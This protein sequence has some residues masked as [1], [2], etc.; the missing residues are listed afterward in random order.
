M[1]VVLILVLVICAAGVCWGNNSIKST[2]IKV[3]I[4]G[5][6]PQLS[7]FR[8]VQL[9]DLHGKIFGRDDRRLVSA[10]AEAEPD[11]IAITGDVAGRQSEL[12]GLPGLAGELV[13]IA[14]VYYVTGNHEWAAGLTKKID[15]IFSEYGVTVLHSDYAVMEKGGGRLVIAGIDDPN[16]PA[17]ARTASELEAEIRSED[18]G[19][20]IILL[21]HRNDPDYYSGLGVSLVL[22]GH[23]HGGIVRIPGIGGV[24]GHGFSL[25]PQ[26]LDG[27]F[28]L[29]GGVRM[30]V[31]R[32]LGNN[33]FEVRIFNRPELPVLI[34]EG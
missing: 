34:L 3:H 15:R 9:S 21:A 27:L 26:Y 16:G 20:P 29:G 30:F 1:I 23:A 19:S 7:G 12:E 14:P 6:S 13:K 32:G 17:D 4:E 28:D 10:V 2:V 31:S 25:F 11:I 24:L 8:I 22:C 5:L 33:G 18:A